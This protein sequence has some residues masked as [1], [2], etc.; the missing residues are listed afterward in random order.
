MISNNVLDFK[1]KSVLCNCM[2]NG[3]IETTAP[4]Q[5]PRKQSTIFWDALCKFIKAVF[6]SVEFSKLSQIRFDSV[7]IQG[8]NCRFVIEKLELP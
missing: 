2:K 7:L 1:V 8:N 3:T 5:Q 6:Q 4:P